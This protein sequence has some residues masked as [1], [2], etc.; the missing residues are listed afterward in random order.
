MI[1][2]P[3]LKRIALVLAILAGLTGVF[4]F[5]AVSGEHLPPTPRLGFLDW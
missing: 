3:T 5:D 2:R 1:S 4:G